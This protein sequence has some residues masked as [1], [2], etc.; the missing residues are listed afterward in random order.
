M[1]KPDFALTLSFEGIGLLLR[2]DTVWN[3]V[4]D[5][6]LD[7]SD[8]Q[9]A[10]DLLRK[11]AAQITD[12]PLHVKLVLPDEQVKYLRISDPG[13][14]REVQE[15]AVKAALD[16]ATPYSLEE[17]SYDWTEL[18][19]ELT[20]AAVAH[21]TLEEAET[22]TRE[23]GFDPVYFA[24][25]PEAG[26]FGGEP[27]FGETEFARTHSDRFG[28][29]ERDTQAII[30]DGVARPPE[31]ESPDP[32]EEAAPVKDTSEPSRKDAPEEPI[33][34]EGATNPAETSEDEEAPVSSEDTASE[35]PAPLTF[36]SRR[37]DEDPGAVPAL[38]GVTRHEPHAAA[39]T[40]TPGSAV[41]QETPLT[42][43]GE[44]VDADETRHDQSVDDLVISAD[45]TDPLMARATESLREP[46]PD[47]A[48]T[49]SGATSFFSRRSKD[50][51]SEERPASLMPGLR[52]PKAATVPAPPPNV[53]PPA[54]SEKER[55]TIFG[56]RKPENPEAGKSVRNKPRFLGLV[57]T[58]VLLLFLIGV[59]A[60]A[61]IFVD[62]GLSG[63]FG[64]DDTRAVELPAET[65]DDLQ[66][67]GEE[68]MAPDPGAR[69]AALGTEPE[70]LDETATRP[71]PAPAPSMTLQDVQEK[72]AIT[73]IWALAPK[74]PPMPAV[75]SGEDFYL[76]SIDPAIEPQDALALPELASLPSD[77]GLDRQ[78]NPAA[79]GQ[80]FAFDDR[81]LVEATDEGTL[82]PD[83]HMVFAGK[84]AVFP[85][86]LPE[87]SEASSAEDLA[88]GER[89]SDLRPRARPSDLAETNERA[90]LGG[91]SR[92]ELARI[93]PKLRPPSAEAVAQ[94]VRE[95]EEEKQASIPQTP[96][97]VTIALPESVADTPDLDSN[98]TPQAV[99][100]S[101]KPRNRPSDISR[102]VERAEQNQQAVRTAAAP[103]TVAPDIPSQAS[104]AKQ[105]TVRN[106]INLRRVN[107]IGVYGKPS[108][109]R[110]L[111][112]L[113]SGRYKKVK[114]GDRVDG[115]R[116]SAIGDGELLY[117]K[118][119]RSVTLKMPRG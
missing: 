56:A 105:A 12:A 80:T 75:E 107:L 6:P 48:E 82:S 72:Y 117:Q 14:G 119:G 79:P 20:I 8:L 30:I 46:E 11:T 95:Q 114:V 57:L 32:V 59:G 85:T 36:A 24:A 71:E 115:G 108:N 77:G 109:R 62:D 27:F 13:G 94:A 74:A 19:G 112:R 106:A 41:S 73:G 37:A 58:A 17:L 88:R 45:A 7:V 89:L 10:L 22:F 15:A 35:S 33:S 16:G 113:S 23:N 86:D 69:L 39:P 29:I 111:V 61:A 21:E 51:G 84:P 60:W 92:S 3:R 70:P 25:A 44:P 96:G 116:V 55:L 52:N 18:N 43:P 68:A 81:G 99:A 9:G 47:T 76:P 104:V 4:G 31:P 93:R 64:R 101:V 5:V 50:R 78:S 118:N 102:I 103:A 66:I 83:G 38:S 67:E 42:D 28:K 49:E 97:A 87:R 40:I 98:A 65:G 63:F 110:A 1:S 2:N 91:L 26:T 54:T 90:N 34:D 100:T 53:I